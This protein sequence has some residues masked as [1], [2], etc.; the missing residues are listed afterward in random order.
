M[1]SP[2]FW[3]GRTLTREACWM[4]CPLLAWCCCLQVGM[5]VLTVGLWA[6]VGMYALYGYCMHCMGAVCMHTV[7]C[8][9]SSA[10]LTVLCDHLPAVSG[11]RPACQYAMPAP[12]PCASQTC[13]HTV[14][15]PSMLCMLCTLSM[16]GAESS[17]PAR[18]P[19]TQSHTHTDSHTHTHTRTA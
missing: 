5:H 6:C 15:I 3:R 11:C 10:H 13:M 14:L 8:V 19:H 12:A 17:K 1:A 2:S 7:A 16:C 18:H 9:C 4:S